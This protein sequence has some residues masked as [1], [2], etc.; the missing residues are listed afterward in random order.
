MS[1]WPEARLAT[2]CHGKLLSNRNGSGNLSNVIASFEPNLKK[3]RTSALL[4]AGIQML[5]QLVL[6]SSVVFNSSSHDNSMI[7]ASAVL[8]L[9]LGLSIWLYFF[10]VKRASGPKNRLDILEDGI[11]LANPS[12]SGKFGFNEVSS[13]RASGPSGARLDVLFKDGKRAG[14]VAAKNGPVVAEAFQ[15]AKESW[16]RDATGVVQTETR[17]EFVQSS[18]LS[19][20]A[21]IF[22]FLIPIVGF[23]LG[24]VA[25]NEINNSSGRIGGGGLARAAIAVSIVATLLLVFVVVVWWAIFF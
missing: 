9:F 15:K 3:V 19:V 8:V 10:A 12:R 23:I 4:F 5:L 20:V 16:S 11:I 24:L 2:Q 18:T 21:L 7:A 22:A 14:F 13:V 25:L 17:D 1:N 6:W